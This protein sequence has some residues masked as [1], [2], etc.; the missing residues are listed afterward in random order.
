MPTGPHQRVIG[1]KLQEINI[2]LVGQ[3][4]GEDEVVGEGEEKREDQTWSS[5][6]KERGCRALA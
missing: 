3:L 4:S 5:Q 2:L 6:E 1:N